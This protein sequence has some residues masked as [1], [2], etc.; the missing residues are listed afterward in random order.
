MVTATEPQVALTGRYTV[1]QTCEHLGIHRNTLRRY[2]EEGHI[3]CSFRR[4]T[5][6]KIYLGKEILRF[7]NS[8]L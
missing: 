8:Q 2:T 3:K 1:K 6:R 5:A 4:E 7:W